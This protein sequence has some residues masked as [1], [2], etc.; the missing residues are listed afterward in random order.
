MKSVIIFF[1][2]LFLLSGQWSLQAERGDI[3]F[4]E[5]METQTAEELGD[6]IQEAV[7]FPP[8]VLG[9]Q[10]GVQLYKLAYE[11]LDYNGIDTTRATGVFALPID[12]PCT[13]PMLTYGHGLTMKHSG[14]PTGQGIYPVLT[15][16]L[17]ANGYITIAPDYIH[18][19]FDASPGVQAFMH[20]DTEAWA[21]IDMI[22]AVRTFCLENEIHYN[23]EL[24]I[25]GYS[26]GG[27]SSMATCKMMQ[28]QHPE[29]FQVKGAMP[30]GG[31][32]DLSGIA[33]DSLAAPNRVTGEPHALA[34]IVH[35]YL[36]VYADSLEAQNFNFTME[37]LFKSPYDT[38]LSRIFDPHDPFGNTSL[39]DPVPNRMLEDTFRVLFQNDPNFLIRDLLSYNDLYDWVPQMKMRIFHSV[40]DVENPY[41]N[42]TFT[43]NLFLER[44]APDVSIDTINGLALSHS[45]AG[46]FHA[47]SL[48][49]WLEEIREPCII[50]GITVTTTDVQ[51]PSIVPNPFGQQFTIQMNDWKEPANIELFSTTGQL[52]G[53]WT[54]N[55][56]N[57]LP[58]QL[59]EDIADGLYFL[60]FT[61]EQKRYSLAVIHQ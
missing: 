29:E 8:S 26:Q 47:L 10:Y 50:D 25:S 6:Q 21:T 1:I 57:S 31:T 2:G 4:V 18:L 11:T 61:S 39:L 36:N 58:I 34:L 12:F 7:G 23:E 46:L 22:R 56:A 48:R 43:Y 45:D 51:Q 9:I 49:N 24:F 16:G 44:G 17:S 28:E 20:A 54:T 13:P 52:M 41:P 14:A 38:I 55:G 3:I 30:G 5:L 32:F 27:H 59:L 42:V 60:V 35:S 53:R 15:K 19:G 37:D 40:A 33:A